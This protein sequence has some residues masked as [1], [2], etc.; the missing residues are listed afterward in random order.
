MKFSI[1]IPAYKQ[2]YLAEAIDSCL[3]QTYQDFELI[4]VNDHSPE[5]LDAVVSQYD[6]S[7]IRYYVN[8]KN[9]GAIDVVDNWNI[10]LSYAK[11]DYIICMGDDD[12]LLPCCLEEYVKLIEKYPNLHIYH[13]RTEIIDE[14][15]S[16]LDLQ[17]ARPERES[18]YSIIWHRFN[19]RKQFIGDFLFRTEILRNNGGFYKIPLAT[20]SDD[21]SVVIAAIDGG[22]AN[23]QPFGFQYR[24]HSRTISRSNN[25]RMIAYSAKEAHEWYKDF[26]S[27][28]TED[29]C[30]EKYRQLTLAMLPRI[31]NRWYYGMMEQDISANPID[32]CRFWLK[33]KD[34]FGFS[35]KYII[36][37]CMHYMKIKILKR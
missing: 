8:E 16:F 7:R 34:D 26:L 35:T 25:P 22:I 14:N 4:I 36:R 9:C 27:R 2:K 17:E 13:A 18:A 10:C 28:E 11:G 6:D 37:L 29:A 12:R 5:D 19:R 3:A 30:D 15:S 23:M 20:F 21:I 33:V 24:E 32:A 31:F 1:T